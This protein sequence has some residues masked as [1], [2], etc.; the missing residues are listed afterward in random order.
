VHRSGILAESQSHLSPA[1]R[2]RAEFFCSLCFNCARGRV[3]GARARMESGKRAVSG[4]KKRAGTWRLCDYVN[5]PTRRC[6]FYGRRV[7]HAACTPSFCPSSLSLLPLGIPSGNNF[8]L[9]PAAAAG[10][11]GLSLLCP[12]RRSRGS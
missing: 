12:R 4:R 11:S 1:G 5:A 2:V 8:F 10:M 6:V 3:A 9:S 7:W